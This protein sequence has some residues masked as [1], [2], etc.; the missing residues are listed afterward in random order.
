VALGALKASLK[1]LE[2]VA[3]YHA[4]KPRVNI[5]EVFNPPR[6]DAP[7]TLAEACMRGHL[8]MHARIWLGRLLPCKWPNGRAGR[9]P[10]AFCQQLCAT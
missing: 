9:W 6:L 10:V 4:T 1:Q 8:Y 2:H 7:G 3:Q 5:L